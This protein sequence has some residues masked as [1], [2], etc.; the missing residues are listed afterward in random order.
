M[1]DAL[2]ELINKPRSNPD[3]ARFAK[4]LHHHL[5]E[6]FTFL[7]HANVDAT[8]FR[9][10][11]AIRP[12]VVNR[13]VWGGNRTW[14]GAHAQAVLSSVLVTCDQL[15]RSPILFLSKVLTATQPPQLIPRA[16]DQVRSRLSS[17]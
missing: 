4:H 13:K 7:R 14:D 6:R 3:H 8:N 5:S 1:E 16:G 15:Y 11:L 12:A 17:K 10:E 9:A 2:Q